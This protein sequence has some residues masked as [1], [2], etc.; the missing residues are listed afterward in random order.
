VIV[1]IGDVAPYDS[2]TATAKPFT[3][4]KYIAI[5]GVK[6]P[7][8][9][10]VTII[11][12]NDGSV[13]ISTV[14]P[15][16]LTEVTDELGKVVGLKGE[17]GV[18]YGVELS[19]NI[20]GVKT[21][22]AETEIDV[23][24]LPINKFTSIDANSKI[25][26]CLINQL[27]DEDK[28]KLVYKYIFSLPKIVSTLAIY[29]DMAFL[30]SIGQISAPVDARASAVEA[31][32][33]YL[34]TISSVLQT[35]A[36]L[37]Q[38]APSII[39]TVFSTID[40]AVLVPAAPWPPQKAPGK[41]VEDIET[42]ALGATGVEG[43]V[44]A[45]R[46]QRGSGLFVLGW[47]QWDQVLIRNSKSR[48]KKIFKTYYNSANGMEDILAQIK[49]NDRASWT[50]AKNLKSR[51]KPSPGADLLPWWKKRKLRSNPFDAKGNLCEKK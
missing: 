6:H 37:M 15:G 41:Y 39:E 5:E 23:L 4:E 22:I 10:A 44:S 8:S 45:Y 1:P 33:T 17:L 18:R 30:P 14:Y 16:T 21:S 46:R 3:I 19:V 2:V 38:P 31:A 32:Q 42:G 24:D 29:N 43:W 50:W 20:A 9:D 40:P 26:L 51:L 27:K 34:D 28:F 25:L 11:S 48:I 47:N 12:Q 36:L 49:G 13:N 35:A 7:P